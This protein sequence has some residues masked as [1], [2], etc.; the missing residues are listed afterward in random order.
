MNATLRRLNWNMKLFT[1]IYNELKVNRRVIKFDKRI[2]RG[3]LSNLKKFSNPVR[4]VWNL[5]RLI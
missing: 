5:A 3:S 1:M 4:L 2:T